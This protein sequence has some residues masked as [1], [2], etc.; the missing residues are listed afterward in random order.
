MELC[1]IQS[2]TA[3]ILQYKN[4]LVQWHGIC[5]GSYCQQLSE[6]ETENQILKDINF[7]TRSGCVIRFYVLEFKLH[8]LPQANQTMYIVCFQDIIC[9]NI[10][11]KG[12][13]IAA[14]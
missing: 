7:K 9:F 6:Y 4:I 5:I 14:V 1:Y 3:L 8:N 13:K 10:T 12:K 11:A 2:T